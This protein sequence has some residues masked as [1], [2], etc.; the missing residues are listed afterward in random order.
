MHFISL[1]RKCDTKFN[2]NKYINQDFLTLF[3]DWLRSD[4]KCVLY[5]LNLK[6][7]YDILNI[8][9]FTIDKDIFAHLNHLTITFKNFEKENLTL[10]FHHDIELTDYYNDE[11][12]NNKLFWFIDRYKR[13][14][15][16]LIELIKS[17]KKLCFIYKNSDNIIDF[18]TDIDEF[19]K[20][21]KTI[22]ENVNYLL[23]ILVE[24]EEK[25][26]FIKYENYLKINLSKFIQEGKIDY[27]DYTLSHIEWEK[28]FTIIKHLSI[29]DLSKM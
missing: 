4:F 17:D 6:N 20:V 10:I 12:L 13:R 28:I 18:E 26:Q 14:F 29:L 5:I 7:I 27:S 19:E 8:D 3:F 25:Y 2:I 9:N 21:L 11:E 22:N 16:R 15:D 1:G 23:V 24:T